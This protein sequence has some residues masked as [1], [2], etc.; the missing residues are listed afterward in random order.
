MYWK[1]CLDLILSKIS[2]LEEWDIPNV[3]D[4]EAEFCRRE[5]QILDCVARNIER[6]ATDDQLGTPYW[7]SL[8]GIK[9]TKSGM[10]KLF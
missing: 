2:S 8:R 10:I 1:Q 4:T 9:R 3:N 6:A 7:D 5:V